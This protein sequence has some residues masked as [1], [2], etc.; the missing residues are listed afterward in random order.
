MSPLEAEGSGINQKPS[1][2]YT[3][4][5][6]A[7]VTDVTRALK[8][9]Q[10]LIH[11]FQELLLCCNYNLLSHYSFLHERNDRCIKGKFNVKTIPEIA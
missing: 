3:R 8:F 11:I 2:H 4:P 9:Y 5:P 1:G 6:H 10:D 7:C